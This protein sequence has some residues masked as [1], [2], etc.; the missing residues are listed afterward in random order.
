MS[1]YFELAVSTLYSSCFLF[2]YSSYTALY[3][4]HNAH[5]KDSPFHLHILLAFSSFHLLLV[6]NFSFHTL[7]VSYRYVYRYSTVDTKYLTFQ[8]TVVNIPTTHFNFR[9][10]CSFST[11]RIYVFFIIHTITNIPFTKLTE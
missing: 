9:K 11:Q 6:P 5:F 4:L 10:F 7:R 1:R 2:R 8:S 3:A